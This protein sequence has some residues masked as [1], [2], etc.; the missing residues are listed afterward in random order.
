MSAD[1]SDLKREDVFEFA[2]ST[3][4]VDKVVPFDCYIY[5]KLN[6]KI[7]LYIRE[8]TVFTTEQEQR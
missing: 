1:R 4:S 5:L 2:A 8:G 7:I 6:E 3:I